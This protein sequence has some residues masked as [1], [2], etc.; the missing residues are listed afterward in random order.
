MLMTMAVLSGHM[1]LEEPDSRSAA[2]IL[3]EE[4]GRDISEFQVPEEMDIPELEE[5]EEHDAKEFYSEE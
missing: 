2:E 3:A 5:L 4:T 1:A